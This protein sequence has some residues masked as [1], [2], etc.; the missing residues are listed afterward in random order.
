MDRTDT[1]EIT[2]FDEMD[3]QKDKEDRRRQQILANEQK[4]NEKKSPA[5]A[6]MRSPNNTN[7]NNNSNTNYMD[8]FESQS[9]VNTKKSPK[10]STNIYKSAVPSHNSQHVPLK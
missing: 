9:H 6:A 10:N 2:S 5:H 7:P 3:R 1:D 8:S 4:R